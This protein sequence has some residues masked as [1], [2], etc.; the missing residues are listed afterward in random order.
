MSHDDHFNPD[1]DFLIFTAVLDAS[2]L[3]SYIIPIHC[4][5]TF[6]CNSINCILTARLT[7]VIHLSLLTFVA[8]YQTFD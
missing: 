2:N 6:K 4:N 5:K 1:S 7:S 8:M 3:S